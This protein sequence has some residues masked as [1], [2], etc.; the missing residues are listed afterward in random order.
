MRP[1]IWRALDDRLLGRRSLYAK[2]ADAPPCAPIGHWDDLD[3]LSWA[4]V[5]ATRVVDATPRSVVE[6]SPGRPGASDNAT[7]T[8]LIVYEVYLNGRF[9]QPIGGGHPGDMRQ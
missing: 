7:P 2:L 6:R 3:N 4:H 9:D 1:A 5:S 8:S